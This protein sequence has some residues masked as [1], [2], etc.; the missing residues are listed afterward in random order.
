MCLRVKVRK[1][2]CDF[3]DNSAFRSNGSGVTAKFKL[4]LRVIHNL[5]QSFKSWRKSFALTSFRGF[6]YVRTTTWSVFGF[7][8]K[9]LRQ[10]EQRTIHLY[11]FSD[12]TVDLR[13][14]VAQ[15]FN[16]SF[17]I[18]DEDFSPKESTWQRARSKKNCSASL[19]LTLPILS[20]TS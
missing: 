19:K 3:K 9:W 4:C 11:P 16:C 15:I 6:Y 14:R 1:N 7:E 20:A 18:A 13:T 5:Q 10:F 8:F 2:A 12:S 17:V